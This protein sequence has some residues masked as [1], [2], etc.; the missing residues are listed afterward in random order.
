[1]LL[2]DSPMLFMTAVML[3]AWLGGGRVGAIAT[4]LAAGSYVFFFIPP[5]FTFIIETTAEGLRV[6]L[7]VAEGLTISAMA[8]VLHRAREN[9]QRALEERDQFVAMA[10]HEL[11]S[12]I[13][14]LRTTLALVA[15]KNPE[16]ERVSLA[17]KQVERLIRLVTDLLERTRIVSGKLSLERVDTDLASVVR[18]AVE[19]VSDDAAAAGCAIHVRAPNAPVVGCWDAQ[20][21]EQVVVNLLANAIKYGDHKPIEVVVEQAERE[22]CVVVRDRGIGIPASEHANIFEPY[23]RASTGRARGIPGTGLGLSIVQAI[24]REHGGEV[25]VKS[26]PGEGTELVVTLPLDARKQNEPRALDRVASPMT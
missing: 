6:A 4:I 10:S 20:R 16:D 9:A 11:K 24:I 15:R 13:T 7:F 18:N 19:L 8:G 17:R 25:R 1:V 3:G 21:L 2:D 14:T 22:A 12:P 5:R 23:A 26:A